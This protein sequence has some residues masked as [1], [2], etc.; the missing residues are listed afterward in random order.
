MLE[1][2]DG[3]ATSENGNAVKMQIEGI[4]HAKQIPYLVIRLPQSRSVHIMAQSSKL[5]VPIHTVASEGLSKN[6]VTLSLLN[7][8]TPYPTH[9]TV[10]H[11]LANR[12]LPLGAHVIYGQS[13]QME[14]QIRWQYQ[15]WLWAGNSC[16][17]FTEK[18]PLDVNRRILPETI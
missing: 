15:S 18:H 14:I 8:P 13:K 3:F 11:F 17:L 4:L 6:Y 9:I 16:L 10:G 1:P 7:K 12:L 5:E 2:Y